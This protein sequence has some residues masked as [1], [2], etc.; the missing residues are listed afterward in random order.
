MQRV[1]T[2]VKGFR[3]IK[4]ELIGNFSDSFWRSRVNSILINQPWAEDSI[5]DFVETWNF[6]NN[7]S[8]DALLFVYWAICRSENPEPNQSTSS[9]EI[10]SSRFQVRHSN[11]TIL[12]SN[13]RPRWHQSFVLL[14]KSRQVRSVTSFGLNI[15]F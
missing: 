13:L 4:T 1:L 10:E 5:K 12:K 9:V 14:E 6:E 15:E 2:H 11:V 3:F 7:C 8:R